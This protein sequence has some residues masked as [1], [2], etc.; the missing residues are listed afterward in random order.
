MT[1]TSTSA[2]SAVSNRVR[3]GISAA[4]TAIGPRIAA[5]TI[6]ASPLTVR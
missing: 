2:L 3:Q 5:S 1:S 6:Q 4:A